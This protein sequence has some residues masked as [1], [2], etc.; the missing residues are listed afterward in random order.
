MYEKYMQQLEE[1]GRIRNLTQSTIDC[2]RNYVSVF[3][4]CA[5]KDP[6]ALT[7]Q[8]VR[9][10]LLQKK[11][12]GLKAAT[13]NLYN[14]SI[15]F[16]Y[17]NVLRILWDDVTVPRMIQEHKLPTVLSPSEVDRLLDATG[18][19]KYRAMFATMYSS[20][21]RVSE[22]IHLHY[23][24]ISRDHMHIHVRKA[25]N[26]QDRYT[27]LSKRNLDLLTEY[28]FRCEN[29]RVSFSQTGLQATT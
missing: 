5:G 29:R 10:F 18:N 3:L 2:Y 17:K 6:A 19:I 20:G 14:S 7:C 13:L 1:E 22:V 11:D 28:W 4:K 16:F 26:R 24:D 21:L 12:S 15:R 25:K 23:R 8:D 9:Q 27:V